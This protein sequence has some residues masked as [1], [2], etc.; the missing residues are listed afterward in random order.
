[1]LLMVVPE[2]EHLVERERGCLGISIWS[3]HHYFLLISFSGS[4]GGRK[5]MFQSICEKDIIQCEI[6]D[7]FV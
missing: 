3:K 2:V 6:E 1:M 7:V 4:P 5:F